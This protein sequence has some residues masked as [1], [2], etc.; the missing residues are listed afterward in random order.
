[1]RRLEALNVLVQSIDPSVRFESRDPGAATNFALSWVAD[2]PPDPDSG[3][4]RPPATAMI[5]ALSTQS[6]YTDIRHASTRFLARL[7]AEA[8]R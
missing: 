8:G 7:P 6:R 3:R 5:R 2:S 1:M 4:F